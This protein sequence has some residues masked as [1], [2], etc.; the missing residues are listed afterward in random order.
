M[1]A[2]SY[3]NRTDRRSGYTLFE[4]LLVLGLIGVFVSMTVPSVMRMFR[5]EKLMGAAEKI[6]TAVAV[7]RVRAI[8]SGLIYQFCCEL[9]GS[10]YVVAPFEPD[11]L[12]S[13]GASNQSSSNTTINQF[14]RTAGMLPK[15]IT[16]SSAIAM[17]PAAQSGTSNAPGSTTAPSQTAVPATGTYKLL[18]ASLDGLPN[19][20]DLAN[21]NWSTPILFNADGSANLDTD[22]IVSDKQA[23]R[24][25]IHVRAF[26]GSASMGRIYEEKR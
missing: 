25:R 22:I 9:N 12:G 4:V 24:V 16:A 26:T 18:P 11:H 2:L 14:G 10:H 6:R 8:E 1:N 15:G 17:N 19:A 7:A 20:A 3:A 13:L 21:L 23:Q 5:Q